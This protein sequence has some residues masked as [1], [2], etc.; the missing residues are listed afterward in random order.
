M[1]LEV[2]PYSFSSRLG[3][4][5]DSAPVSCSPPL[6]VWA[7]SSRKNS[8]ECVPLP[9]LPF[10]PLAFPAPSGC[11]AMT[12]NRTPN[13]STP[14]ATCNDADITRDNGIRRNIANLPCRCRPICQV[15][16]IT[17]KSGAEPG[18]EGQK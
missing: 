7:H 18:P 14:I 2:V 6:A 9:S 15:Q 8:G 12:P 5:T 17:S 1:D 4:E 16:Y 10:L 3:L 13:A 11:C